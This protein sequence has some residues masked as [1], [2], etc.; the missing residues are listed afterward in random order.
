MERKRKGINADGVKEN[1]TNEDRS[2]VPPGQNSSV[3]QGSIDVI[4]R[5]LS[6]APIITITIIQIVLIIIRK[7]DPLPSKKTSKY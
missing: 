4:R 7:E 1:C 2:Y 6:R 5:P 3:Q